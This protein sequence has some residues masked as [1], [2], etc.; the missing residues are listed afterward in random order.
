[1]SVVKMKDNLSQQGGFHYTYFVLTDSSVLPS[2]GQHS[3]LT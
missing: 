2:A 1:M 3:F